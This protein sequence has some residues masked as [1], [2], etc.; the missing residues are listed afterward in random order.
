M[1]SGL[2][3]ALV[4]A[5]SPGE[6]QPPPTEDEARIEELMGVEVEAREAAAQAVA[7][8][9]AQPL[10]TDSADAPFPP[11]SGSRVA[12]DDLPKLVGYSI[13]VHIGPRKRT[14]VIQKADKKAV[15]MKAP[16]GGGF[17]SFTL[18]RSQI[19]DI[20]IL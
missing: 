20:E 9:A 1:L 17:A 18:S 5:I 15:T 6:P 19:D 7:E 13:R 12:F 10:E 8:A 3:A 2:L 14:G 4:L 16:M 11:P